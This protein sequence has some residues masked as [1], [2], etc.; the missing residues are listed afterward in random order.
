MKTTA[1]TG[2]IDYGNAE[3]QQA[4]KNLA[5]PLQANGATYL[6]S[7]SSANKWKFTQNTTTTITDQEVLRLEKFSL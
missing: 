1:L 5:K 3:Q 2:V 7:T 4:F 6:R